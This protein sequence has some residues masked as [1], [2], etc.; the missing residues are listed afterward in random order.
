MSKALSRVTCIF[1]KNRDRELH[2]ESAY[3]NVSE[4]E[5]PRAFIEDVDDE[6]DV[7][8][9]SISSYSTTATMDDNPGPGRLMDKHIYQRFG[10]KIERLVSRITMSNLPPERIVQFFEERFSG[11]RMGFGYAGYLGVIISDITNDMDDCADVKGDILLAG[12]KSL[13]KQSQ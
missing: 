4:W 3:F 12:L 10:R 1:K 11:Y 8:T 13:V 7:D 9:S 2:E 5:R 6:D